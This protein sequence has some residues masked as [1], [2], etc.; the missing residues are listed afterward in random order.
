MAGNQVQK[1][2]W[3]ATLPVLVAV[4]DKGLHSAM[5]SPFRLFFIVL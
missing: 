5:F 4:S 1:G 3:A 2:H